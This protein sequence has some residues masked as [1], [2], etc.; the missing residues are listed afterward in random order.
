MK[1]LF[2]YK[3]KYGSYS[4][5]LDQHIIKGCVS[6]ALGDT[7]SKR[8]LND[9]CTIIADIRPVNWAYLADMR[10]CEGLTGT[11]EKNLQEAYLYAINNGC[12]VDAYCVESPVA[13]DQMRRIRDKLGIKGEIGKHVFANLHD[14]SAFI[15]NV[16]ANIK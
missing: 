9:M 13:I 16:M 5:S 2:K 8:F 11:A 15:A 1:P 6:G 10:K 12:V 4:L 3:D 7:L 14:A